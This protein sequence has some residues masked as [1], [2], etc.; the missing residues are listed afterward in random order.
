MVQSR[1]Q[2]RDTS[3]WALQQDVSV[4]TYDSIQP[5]QSSGTTGDS[6]VRVRTNTLSGD[7]EVY[8]VNDPTY[9]SNYVPLSSDD[10]LIYSYG[11]SDDNKTIANEDLYEEFFTA[12]NA[13]QD[14]QLEIST[15]QDTLALSST[16]ASTSEQQLG[17]LEDSKG[18]ES[19]SNTGTPTD[20]N[21]GN[22]STDG[23]TG[24]QPLSS[25]PTQPPTSST[26]PTGD[27]SSTESGSGV[28]YRYPL[29]IPDLGYDYIKIT[30]YEYISNMA[31]TGALTS[32]T[33][34]GQSV[35]NRYTNPLETIILPMQ[36][37]ISETNAVDWGGDK[38]NFLQ[39]LGATTAI[40]AMTA[41]GALDI[42]GLGEAASKAF[43]GI[44]QAFSDEGTKKFIAAY[45]S[46]IHI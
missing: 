4:H 28:Q 11:A 44:S 38:L 46:L 15:K 26:T 2:D 3:G 21:T 10:T 42:A 37:N 39:N 8:L 45:L 29:N 32:A 30:S 23:T 13:N 16:S 31:A 20:P 24:A 25:D 5:I 19:L 40:D 7:Y 18:Y 6:R 41:A 35:T 27:V 36:P 9:A 17:E 12:D 33:Q 14:T 43:E 34:P 22:Q 1:Y